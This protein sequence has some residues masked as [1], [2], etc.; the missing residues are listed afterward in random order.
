[1]N[2]APFTDHS[3]AVSVKLCHIN[4]GRSVPECSALKIHITREAT[5][6]SDHSE[7]CENY[8][9]GRLSSKTESAQFVKKSSRTTPMLCRT[10][11]GARE[12]EEHGEMI[13]PI[14][15]KPRTGGAME[16]KDHPEC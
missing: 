8:S 14:I 10:T 7:R 9:T 1:M 13:I 15:F 12:W 4:P 11:N 3:F 5:E 6:S 2:D 16:Q